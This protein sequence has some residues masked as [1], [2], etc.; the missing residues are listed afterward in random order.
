MIFSIILSGLVKRGAISAV[1]FINYARLGLIVVFLGA[2]LAKADE[3]CVKELLRNS[4]FHD[5]YNGDA[6]D[7]EGLIAQNDL[8]FDATDTVQLCEHLSGLA[9][10]QTFGQL[11]LKN[12]LSTSTDR[13]SLKVFLPTK[14]LSLIHI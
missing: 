8:A 6:Y 9:E 10:D 13:G 2:G 3:T 5:R 14:S 12:Y 1:T 11:A 7:I 4:A